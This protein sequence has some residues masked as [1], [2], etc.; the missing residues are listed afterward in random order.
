M[1]DALKVE[2]LKKT[3]GDREIL[4]GLDFRLPQGAMGLY[5]GP[6]G[7]GKTS[8][9]RLLSGLER[10]DAGAIQVFGQPRSDLSKRLIGV[11]LEEPRFYPWLTGK[12]TLEIVGHYRQV[13]NPRKWAVQALERVGLAHA[14]NRPSKGYSL[15][16]RQRLYL[17]SQLFPEVKLLLLDEPTNGL[18]LEGREQLWAVLKTLTGEGV[19]ML[20]STHQVLEAERYAEHLVVI[21]AGQIAYQG[22]Y[23]QLA[24]SRRLVVEVDD[25]ERARNILGLH[26]LQTA[27]A[28]DSRAVVVDVNIK[29]SRQVQG[30]L[31][32]QNLTV[33]SSRPE[34]LEELYW[35]IKDAD[36][37]VA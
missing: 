25:P 29:D 23:A 5:L 15:G 17:A 16:M 20:V 32:Q 30:I 33:L 13:E 28:R 6:N 12:E 8:T 21:H 35:R 19:S 34:D 27:A 1:H 37:R 2:G 10:P 36:S 7:A 14:M 4:K 22:S 24:A 11:T 9:F 3:Y 18:D 26:G 31:E